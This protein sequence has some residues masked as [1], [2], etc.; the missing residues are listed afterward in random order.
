[1]ITILNQSRQPL[2]I[3]EDYL[4]DEITEQINGAYTLKFSVVLDEEKSQYIQVGNIA[5]VEGV[6]V[7]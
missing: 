2:A 6:N 5:E 4:D 7:K 3:L 1:M